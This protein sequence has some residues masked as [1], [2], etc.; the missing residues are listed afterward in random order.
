M[1]KQEWIDALAARTEILRIGTP[2]K[3]SQPDGTL[4]DVDVYSVVVLEQSSNNAYRR[5]AH[6]YV[7][8]EGQPS[9]AAYNFQKEDKAQLL[10][11]DTVKDALAAY[12]DGQSSV[13]RYDIALYNTPQQESKCAVVRAWVETGVG[14]CEIQY[15]LVYKDGGSPVA[16]SVISNWL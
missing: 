12:M 13:L 16:H 11:P 5:K 10:L 9:E 15:W 7:V 6:F 2:V 14:A 3:I 1:T 8:D 4:A